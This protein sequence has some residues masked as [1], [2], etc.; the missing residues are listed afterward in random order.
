MI[1]TAAEL[2]LS[3]AAPDG[4]IYL[5]TGSQVSYE[6]EALYCTTAKADVSE[7]N[8]SSGTPQTFE[9]LVKN[10]PG[11]TSATA[12]ITVVIAPA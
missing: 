7:L 12:T 1:H 10:G 11:V 5:V 2:A 8:W 6:S 4:A 3:E 9:V